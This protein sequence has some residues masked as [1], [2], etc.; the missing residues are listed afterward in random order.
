MFRIIS[1]ETLGTKIH[2]FKIEAPAIARKALA[3]QFVVIRID[4]RDERIPLTLADWDGKGRKAVLRGIYGSGND[5]LQ[6]GAAESR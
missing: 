5:N 6:A 4:E 3:G 2:L 1:R